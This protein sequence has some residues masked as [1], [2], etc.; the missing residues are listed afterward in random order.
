VTGCRRARARNSSS[1]PWSPG[2]LRHSSCSSLVLLPSGSDTVRR[3]TMH[4]ARAPC[5]ARSVPTGS[6]RSRSPAQYLVIQGSGFGEISSRQSGSF[7]AERA[8]FEPA[9]ELPP[10]TLSKRAPSASRTP[11]RRA[12]HLSKNM[13][14]RKGFEPLDLVKGQ[15]FSRPPRSTTPAPLLVRALHSTMIGVVWQRTV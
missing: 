3:T 13:A 14:E 12:V 4:R 7:M 9:V 8:G 15:R 1:P 10:H 2:N 11:L 6:S 5:R